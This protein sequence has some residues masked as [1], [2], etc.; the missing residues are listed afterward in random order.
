MTPRKHDTGRVN[1][2]ERLAS[3][4]ALIVLLLIGALAL[5]G[6]AGVI[7]WG[8]NAA[9]LQAHSKRIAELRETKAALE[10][11]VRL[12]DPD[13]VDPDLGSE[14]VRHNLGVMHPDEYVIEL[15]MPDKSATE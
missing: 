14:L 9:M 11:R 13:N 4:F 5:F 15:D 10:N 12:L 6:P 3:A 7:A 1:L 8:E 2:G